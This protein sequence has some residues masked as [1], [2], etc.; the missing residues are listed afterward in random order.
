MPV[1]LRQLS[2][3][4]LFAV[5]LPVIAIAGLAFWATAQFIKPA[6]PPTITMSTGGENGAYQRFA[7]RYREIFA[8]H[9]IDLVVLPSAGAIENLTR[10]RD[11]D[12]SVDAGFIQGGT[13]RLQEGDDLHAL[14]AFYYEPLWIFYRDGLQP[15]GH[16]EEQPEL[17]NLTTI[18][19]LKGKRIAIGGKG[20]GTQNLALEMLEANGIDRKNTKLIDEGGMSL[21]G[22]F[23][24]GSIDAVFAVG[25]TES[26]LVWT[27]LYTPGVKL[28][29]VAHAEAYTRRVPSLAQLKLPRGAIDLVRD[30]PPHDVHLVAPM[31][32][33]MV[34]G[35]THPALVG[36]L[37]QAASEVHG[38]PGVFQRQGQFPHTAHSEFP[39]SAEAARYYASGKP[40]LQ[41][42]LPFWA[43][44]LVDRLVVMLVPLLAILF[45]LF[46]FAPMLYAW[47]VRSRI[48]RQYGELKFIESELQESPDRRSSEEWLKRL[49]AL[50]KEANLLPTPLAFTDMLYTLRE[51]IAMVRKA[52]I[53]R[54]SASTHPSVN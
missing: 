17:E 23:A 31:S 52:V 12:F 47:R 49:D 22:Q 43:A 21:I 34:R 4:D 35:E 19:Q 6:P 13:A 39:L 48:Y 11:P 32:T 18:A 45:P 8:R 30:I 28:M 26:A 41:R 38:E 51:H 2:F 20:S 1:K 46:R 25:P 40:F 33:V 37:M 42:Y 27:L 53:R 29:S 44:T 14:G 7:L 15:R 50:E 9:G 24:D 10:L 5:I 54:A 36:M 3:R 16:S